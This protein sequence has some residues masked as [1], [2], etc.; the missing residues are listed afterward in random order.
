MNK[1]PLMEK[2][3]RNHT[4]KNSKS[5]LEQRSQKLVNEVMK[6]KLNATEQIKEYVE[7]HDYVSSAIE[8][9][10]LASLSLLMSSLYMYMNNAHDNKLLYLWTLVA[11]LLVVLFNITKVDI[12]STIYNYSIS[13][14]LE[15]DDVSQDEAFKYKKYKEIMNSHEEYRVRKLVK[16]GVGQVNKELSGEPV[17]NYV[18][19]L[20]RHIIHNHR[21]IAIRNSHYYGY[22]SSFERKKALVTLVILAAMVLLQ[23]LVGI[24]KNVNELYTLIYIFIG[25]VSIKDFISSI[26]YEIKHKSDKSIIETFTKSLGG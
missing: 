22:L 17:N 10:K 8:L 24:P 7:I 9:S 4:K 14:N 12:E 26:E 6:R 15:Y 23:G 5:E 20:P 1:K 3:L 25:I 16:S 21:D 19:P 18:A 13:A 11:I 2:A